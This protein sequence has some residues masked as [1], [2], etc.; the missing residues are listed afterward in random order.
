MTELKGPVDVPIDQSEDTPSLG[1]LL[2]DAC[3]NKPSLFAV[4]EAVNDICIH[5]PF[6][7]NVNIIKNTSI[8]NTLCNTNMLQQCRVESIYYA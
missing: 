1:D 2:V 6:K 3:Y 8:I 4:H 7:V 5:N